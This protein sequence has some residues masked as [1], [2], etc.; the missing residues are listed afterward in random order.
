MA[1]TPSY[2]WVT[3]SPTDFV[4]DLPADFE[5]FADAVDADLAGLLGGTTGQVLTKISGTDHD[6]AFAAPAGGIPD[7]IFDAKGDLIAATAADTAAR[8]AV[9]ANG[10]V[11]TADSGET[12]GL[13]WAAPSGLTLLASGSLSGAATTLSSIPATYKHLLLSIRR[14][15]VSTGAAKLRLRINNNTSGSGHRFIENR[16]A[17]GGSAAVQYTATTYIEPLPSAVTS[18]SKSN[19]FFTIYD[20]AQSGLRNIAFT[21]IGSTA[22]DNEFSQGVGFCDVG[23]SLIDRLDIIPS[24]GSWNDGDYELY[25][26]N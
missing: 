2:G 16:R 11:L 4:T 18:I 14:W 15:R 9:G 8:L 10:T 24:T 13:K 20:Y 19:C 17:A 21:S 23:G 7:T 25:G 12:T 1:I 6:F 5:V 26:V 22:T 3:P